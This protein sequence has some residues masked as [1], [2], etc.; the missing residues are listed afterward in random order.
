VLP[1]IRYD[2]SDVG[3]LM[4]HGCSCGRRFP[5]FELSGGR[6]RSF[7]V[8]RDGDMIPEMNIDIPEVTTEVFQF[9][10]RQR[11]PGRMRR[12]LVRKKGFN[13]S[14]AKQIR[15]KIHDE[16]KGNIEV[17]IEYVDQIPPCESGKNQMFIQEMK[18]HPGIGFQ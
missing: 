11:E 14:D 3:C 2:T 15:H 16:F 6:I 1:L 9:Q 18:D 17:E 13:D 5:L 10:F 8:A 12:L 4:D 7:A